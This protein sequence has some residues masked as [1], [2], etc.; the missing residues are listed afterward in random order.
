MIRLAR[1]L[2]GLVTATTFVGAVAILLMIVHIAAD[3]VMR[4]IFLDPIA[5]TAVVVANYYMAIVSFL[6]VA[7]AEKLDQHVAVDL[8]YG[9][10]PE[11]VQIWILRAVRLLV[12]VVAGFAAY[13]F[14][15]D[16][17]RKLALDSYVRESGYNVPDWPG[18]FMLPIGFGLLSLL[19]LFKLAA[20]FMGEEPQLHSPRSTGIE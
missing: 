19:L 16:A 12:A 11:R 3:V 7:L 9:R 15:Q 4:N 10:F 8:V 1:I 2:S 13:G 5:A 6:P 20:S 17:L 14:L 18:Y